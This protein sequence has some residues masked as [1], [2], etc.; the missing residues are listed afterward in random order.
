[1]KSFLVLT[2]P[3]T[4]IC[5]LGWPFPIA[6]AEDA[7]QQP[8]AIPTFHCIGLYWS[9]PGG[10]PD[11]QVLVRFR[12][13]GEEAWQQGLPMRYNPIP[14]TDQDLADYRGSLV[15]LTPGTKYEIELQLEGTDQV[16]RLVASTWSEEFPI[17]EVINVPGGKEPLAITE[18]G[19]PDAYR[20][21]DGQGAVIDVEH[22]HDTC[23]SI[24]ASYVI[25]RNFVL[26]GAG[27]T[28]NPRGSPI[29]AIRIDK[30]HDI[31]IED[32]DISDWGR[33][34]P[35]TGF[36]FDYDAA[37]LCRNR[38][39]HRVIIQRCR[40]HHPFS[41]T[42]T[43]YEPVYPR[44]PKVRSASPS[45]TPPEIMSSGTTK[46]IPT[47]TTCITTSWAEEAMAATAVRQV[48]ILIFMAI[49]SATAGTMAWKSRVATGTCGFGGITSDNAR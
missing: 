21:Y 45:L 33:T 14:K 20:V 38:D 39:V 15:H 48:T 13:Q 4:V 31:V 43:W 32:C 6:S 27:A 41:D 17:G 37:V 19:R 25:V 34:N 42:N 18:S 35:K 26:K 30:G 11:R 28:N 3:V 2:V 23:I 5:V 47:S 12:R 44:I 16:A 46:C 7:S 49:S 22:K 8:V 10:S 36:G 24:D 1:M 40:M 29:G 9:P